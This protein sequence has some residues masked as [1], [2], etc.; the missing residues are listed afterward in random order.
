MKKLLLILSLATFSQ[1]T[2]A[3]DFPEPSKDVCQNA[4]LLT[5]LANQMENN[6]N[7]DDLQK[8]SEFIQKCTTILTSK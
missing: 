2:F 3:V 8:Y 4:D 5:K 1:Y 6:K 7:T